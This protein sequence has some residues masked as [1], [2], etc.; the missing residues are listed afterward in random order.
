MLFI[1]GGEVVRE[2]YCATCWPGLAPGKRHGY[3]SCWQGRFKAEPPKV[4][5]EPI[6]KSA[7]ERLL[8]K[9][10]ES[11]DPAR[12]NFRYV[13]A[14]MLE[15]RKKLVPRD[16]VIDPATGRKVL[17]YEHGETGESFLIEDPGLD[18]RRAREVQA[19]IRELMAQEGL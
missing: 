13:L 16:T 4:N 15:R 3:L 2:D 6:G 18:L 11:R 9:Y 8:K 5:E 17:V 14:L 10:S 1:N 7:A 12:V 19:Q